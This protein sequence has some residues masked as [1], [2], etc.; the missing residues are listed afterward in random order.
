MKQ[1]VNDNENGFLKTTITMNNNNVNDQK[2]GRSRKVENIADRLITIFGNEQFR[3]FYCKV[4]W[5]LS[6]AKIWSNVEQAQK[7][8]NPAKLFSYLCKRDG[9]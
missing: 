7:G 6:E 5:K 2:Y 1:P 4:A 9:V 8:N 3:P